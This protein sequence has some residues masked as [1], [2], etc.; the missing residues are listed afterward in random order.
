MGKSTQRRKAKRTAGSLKPL[1][2][3]KWRC[4]KNG[5]CVKQP[6]NSGP[7]PSNTKWCTGCDKIYPYAILANKKPPAE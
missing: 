4:R 1:V 7:F 6:A 2:G 3:K 5:V